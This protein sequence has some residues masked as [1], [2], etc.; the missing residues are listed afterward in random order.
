MLTGWPSESSSFRGGAGLGGLALAPAKLA[1]LVFAALLVEVE[2]FELPQPAAID[3]NSTATPR[4]A[5]GAR[6]PNIPPIIAPQ[7]KTKP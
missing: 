3:A 5:R 4:V 1:A 7:T 6:L 2:E